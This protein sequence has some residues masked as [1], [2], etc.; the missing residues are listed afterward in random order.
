MATDLTA[1]ALTLGLDIGGTKV[2]GVLVDCAGDVPQVRFAA[3]RPTAQGVGG[4]VDSAADVVADLLGEAGLRIDQVAAVGVGVP[5]IVDPATEVVSHAVNLGIDGSVPLGALLAARLGVPVRL[6]NDLNAA[7]IGAALRT[8]GG[9]KR[10]DLAYLALGTGVAAGLVL[11]GTV[12][13]GGSGAAGEI[14]HIPWVPDGLACPCGQ[15]GC[16][17]QYASGAA[18]DAAWP[19]RTGR[20]SPVEVFEAAD[21]GDEDAIQ[22]RDTFA[23]AVAGAV[24]VLVLTCDVRHVVLGG[25]VSALGPPLLDAVR[26]ALAE[27]AAASPFL[28]AMALAERVVLAP[29]GVPVAAIG[30]AL[31]ATGGPESLEVR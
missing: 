12:R 1:G 16:L 23:R 15:R 10:A 13:R 11:D 8:G 2:H 9:V 14:G 25:G 17:E 6:D 24:R 19:S 18:L 21:A 22:V 28:Q 4:V 3:R 5:G 20:P 29:A 26:A 7:A 27:Q 31:L 30:A